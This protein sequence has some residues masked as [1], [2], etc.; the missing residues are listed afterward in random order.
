MT[1]PVGQPI[2]AAAAFQAASSPSESLPKRSST[3]RCLVGQVGRDTL[4][5]PAD[6]L[7][8]T[9]KRTGD[10]IAGATGAL[11]ALL[12]KAVTNGD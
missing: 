12:S 6:L 4:M 8:S 2:L 3:M 9:H 10:K 7:G 11:G 1:N 5:G